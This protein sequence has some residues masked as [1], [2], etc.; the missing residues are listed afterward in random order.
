M[1]YIDFKT[2]L[3]EVSM[4]PTAVSKAIANLDARIGMEFEMVIPYNS[5][6][7]PANNN[8][9]F[10]KDT[11]VGNIDS[12]IRFFKQNDSN[13]T[14]SLIKL[15]ELLFEGYLQYI[16][17]QWIIYGKDY[18]YEWLLEKYGEDYKNKLLKQNNNSNTLLHN[19]IDT[20]LSQYIKSQVDI[21]WKSRNENYKSAKKTWKLNELPME[22]DYLL[23]NKYKMMKDVWDEHNKWLNWPFISNNSDYREIDVKSIADDLKHVIHRPIIYNY[24]YHAAPRLPNT[25]IV[26]PD[27]T[28]T[29]G[30]S[31]TGNI[32]PGTDII[33]N[34]SGIKLTDDFIAANLIGPNFGT[35][36]NIVAVHGNKIQTSNIF[37]K[38]VK[39][40][41]TKFFISTL[42]NDEGVEIISPP[43]TLDEMKHDL[44]KIV[45][46]AKRKK[47]YTNAS[48][49]LHMNIS[50]PNY[51]D[52]SVDFIK[53]VLFLGDEHVL[54]VFN[55]IGN[56][57]AVSA[58]EKLKARVKYNPDRTAAILRRLKLGLHSS[59][60]TILKTE[61]LQQ[62]KK[63]SIN[64]KKNYVEFRSPGGDWLNMDIN[65]LISTLERFIY[66]LD[67]ACSPEKY[68][69]EYSKKLYKL[70]SP[71]E[72]DMDL[73]MLSFFISGQYPISVIKKYLKNNN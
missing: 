19:N 37:S 69:K 25:Y 28:V 67:I 6:N 2:T 73:E 11:S 34:V 44:N 35:L 8:P 46:W 41:P 24:D 7:K 17:Q 20:Q 9:D 42:T 43:L 49:G 27:M 1:R 70:L 5:N 39:P 59:A 61:L 3:Q 68:K 51:S 57:Y 22:E 56:S 23:F 26:E 40:G 62:D 38:K 16:E 53:L 31:V 10:S 45:T 55:R 29:S 58:L 54:D 48:T 72:N 21:I 12:I 63:I 14:K 18:L 65:I 66:A 30:V 33:T 47:A 13:L 52:T 15:K 36:Q 32:E 64:I 60:Q 50:L 4:K 71:I